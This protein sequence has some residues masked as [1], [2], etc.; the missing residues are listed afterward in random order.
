MPSGKPAMLS[1]WAAVAATFSGVPGMPSREAG[2]S[3]GA[4]CTSARVSADVVD[5]QIEIGTQQV[6]LLTL[7]TCQLELQGP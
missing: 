5:P 7:Q 4:A 6:C 2:M 3:P 1:A